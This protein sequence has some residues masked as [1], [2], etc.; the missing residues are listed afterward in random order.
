MSDWELSKMVDFVPT[1]P[2]ISTGKVGK[3]LAPYNPTNIECVHIALD[4]LQI[5]DE[6]VLF[7]L[8]CG[9]GRLLVEV[10]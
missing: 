8:G 2:E 10:S 3:K 9:D 6:D 5:H 7:D 1:P 4:M